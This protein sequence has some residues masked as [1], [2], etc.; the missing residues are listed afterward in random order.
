MKLLKPYLARFKGDVWWAIVSVAV[1]AFATLWQPRVL[2]QIMTAIIANDKATVF[3]L[4]LWLVALGVIGI[5]AGVINTVYSARIALNVATNLRADVYRHV[6]T[7]AYA[8]VEQFSPS[9]LVVRMTND[10]NQIQQVLM[11]V[12][13]QVTRIPL[14][15]FGALVLALVTIPS[16][17]WIIL[18]MMA[19][20]IGVSWFAFQKMGKL[21]GRTQKL[22]ERVNTIARENLMG[23]RVVKSFVQEDNQIKTFAKASDAMRDVN[24]KIGDLFAILMPAFFLACNLAIGVSVFLIGRNITAHPTYLAAISSYTSYLFQIMFAVINAGFMTTFAARAMISIGRLKT[25]MTHAP[26]MH[27]VAGP[28]QPVGGSIAFDHVS[29][30]YPGDDQPTLRDISF[31]VPAGAQV[32]IV[33][34]TGSG[35]TTLAQLIPRLFDPDVGTVTLGGVDL[36][37]LSQATIRDTVSFVLQRSTLFSGTIAANLRQA[38]PSAA[39]PQMER[40]AGIAQAAEFIERLPERYDAPVEERS[41]NFSGGQKQ[42]LAITRGVIAEPKVLILDDATSALDARSEKLVQQALG[43]H[44]AHTTTVIIAEKIS[45]IIH[46]DE[47][48]VLAD[49]RLVGHG[50][51]RELV[52]NNP[53]YQEIYRTQK[54]KEAAQ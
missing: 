38:Q 12:F 43:K 6:Q 25:V 11:A 2:Q 10:I 36:R 41:A 50:T 35:K 48:L 51:H 17:W 21:F 40:A 34:A 31:T 49:G 46:A 42:R 52:A 29:F 3:R 15:F 13:Q 27:F 23:I 44:L 18:V 37:E 7:F 1:V 19:A 24:T 47:I 54:A 8:D 14:L 30:T 32:G 45:S 33:G 39:L 53:T 28:S 9:N 22:V 5:V 26:S 20:I 4:G 16:L